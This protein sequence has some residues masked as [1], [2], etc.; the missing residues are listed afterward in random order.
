MQ[1]MI[2]GFLEEG[3]RE[4]AAHPETARQRPAP[5]DLRKLRRSMFI[6]FLVCSLKVALPDHTLQAGPVLIHVS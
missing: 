5:V 1:R 2:F 3:L 4:R 6:P